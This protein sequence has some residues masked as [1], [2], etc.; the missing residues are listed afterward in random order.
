[1]SGPKYQIIAGIAVTL[2]LISLSNLVHSV[3]RT[4]DTEHLTYT[5]IILILSA[6]SLLVL[7]GLLNN[8][9][10]IYL[11]AIIVVMGVLYILFVK[12]KNIKENKIEME[13][14]NKN[15]L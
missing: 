4:Q 9:Y 8:E 12:L 6:Q 13:L 1:M 14:I 5:W 11:P 3:Y 2:T 10:G 15:I 7:Y